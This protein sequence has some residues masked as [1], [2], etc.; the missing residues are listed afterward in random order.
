VALALPSPPRYKVKPILEDE[1]P[2]FDV[3]CATVV[4]PSF[5]HPGGG[6]EF[7]TTEYVEVFGWY[8]F[9]DASWEAT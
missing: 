6:I 7:C 3:C 5:G 2:Y 8:S 9:D 1:I 4:E